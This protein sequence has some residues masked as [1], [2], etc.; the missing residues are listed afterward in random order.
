[1]RQVS[2]AIGSVPGHPQLRPPPQ[3]PAKHSPVDSSPPHDARVGPP[4]PTV[5]PLD[6]DEAAHGGMGRCTVLTDF[7]Q[8]LDVSQLLQ[9]KAWAD[10][11]GDPRV[12]EKVQKQMEARSI[13][14]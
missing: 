6:Q 8:H 4:P 9:L 14:A 12:I 10:A 2:L 13:R 11:S 7:A 1:M 5:K 3:E